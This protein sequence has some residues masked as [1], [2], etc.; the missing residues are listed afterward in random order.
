MREAQLTVDRVPYCIECADALVERAEAIEIAPRLRELLPALTHGAEEREQMRRAR[1]DLNALDEPELPSRESRRAALDDD[2][3]VGPSWT[4]G[5][6]GHQ[7][8]LHSMRREP[9]SGKRYYT[10]CNVNLCMC[11]LGRNHVY[12]RGLIDT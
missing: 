7:L 3:E 8:Y 2:P 11:T 9:N 1:V 5:T 6:C 4:C 10:I 12:P